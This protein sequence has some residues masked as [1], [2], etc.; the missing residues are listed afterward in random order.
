[1]RVFYDDPTPSAANGETVEVAAPS[2][3]H[4]YGRITFSGAVWVRPD[5]RRHGITR[6]VP[7][8]TRACAFTRWNTPLFWAY[9]DH[10]LDQIGVTRAYGSWHVEDG[11]STH[12]PSWRGDHRILFLSMGQATLIRDIADSVARAGR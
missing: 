4:F 8:L 9:I 10:D 6:I 12:M 11:I 7:R 5:Y 1:L 2:A 3:E